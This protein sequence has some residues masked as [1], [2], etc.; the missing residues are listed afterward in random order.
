[1][2]FSLK[3]DVLFAYCVQAFFFSE[4]LMGPS[5]GQKMCS[6][7]RWCHVHVEYHVL[8]KSSCGNLYSPL[9]VLRINLCTVSGS[10]WSVWTQRIF[11]FKCRC[12]AQLLGLLTASPLLL[13]KM[14]NVNNRAQ[15]QVWG[16]NL[17]GCTWDSQ[18]SA[19]ALVMRIFLG[20]QERLADTMQTPTFLN[21]FESAAGACIGSL[22][23]HFLTGG[24]SEED[25]GTPVILTLL[26]S[27]KKPK[28]SSNT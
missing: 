1:M 19:A 18:C 23:T 9:K 28:F 24:K 27:W 17:L 26:L 8:H 7:A 12:G 3:Q 21:K 22:P 4:S 10:L 15:Q 20:S 6:S 5:G 11:A 13:W 14:L 16:E 25:T 2:V